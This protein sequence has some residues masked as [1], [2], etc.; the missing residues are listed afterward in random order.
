[1]QTLRKLPTTRPKAANSTVDT[2]AIIGVGPLRS[3]AAGAET[4]DRATQCHPRGD[5]AL[6]L[7]RRPRHGRSRR[8]RARATLTAAAP[9]GSRT[10]RPPVVAHRADPSPRAASADGELRCE[11]SCLPGS[12]E[13]A[14]TSDARPCGYRLRQG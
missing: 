5:K 11:T 9:V 12:P 1:M 10:T 7:D 3:A 13:S 14:P 2:A 6:Q 4:S 8:R